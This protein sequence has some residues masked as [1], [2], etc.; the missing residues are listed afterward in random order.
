MNPEKCYIFQILINFF[1][2]HIVSDRKRHFFI[3][4]KDICDAVGYKSASSV[5]RGN[6]TGIRKMFKDFNIADYRYKIP[7][8]A[9]FI[10]LDGVGHI[11]SRS[12]LEDLKKKQIINVLHEELTYL[13]YIIN[14]K[15]GP[16]SIDNHLH[17]VA[18]PISSNICE[19]E[20]T[21]TL[22]LTIN[23]NNKE[24][25]D[26]SIQ[27]QDLIVPVESSE[28][29]F[30]PDTNCEQLDVN[31]ENTVESDI[32][33][34]DHDQNNG[35]PNENASESDVNCERLDV[36]SDNLCDIKCETEMES[37]ELLQENNEQFNTNVTELLKQMIHL[38]RQH[39]QLSK[40]IL[41]KFK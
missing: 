20:K 26:E 6:F 35:E 13:N 32:K 8:N 3:K 41:E 27:Q 39:I 16:P 37:N 12:K 15:Y 1:H 5:T 40:L 18:S 4:A 34:E 25:D 11:I 38:Q 10:T 36:N 2:V 14:C 24:E 28:K 22:S 29:N 23:F 21:K 31:N 9:W 30:E 7:Y 19:Q 17:I 33:C